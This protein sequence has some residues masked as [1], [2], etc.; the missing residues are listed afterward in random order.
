[1]LPGAATTSATDPETY[2]EPTTKQWVI[3]R[4]TLQRIH[5]AKAKRAKVIRVGA[6]V[7]HRESAELKQ[8]CSKQTA[9]LSR[10]TK[11]QIKVDDMKQAGAVKQSRQ[12]PRRGRERQD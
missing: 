9:S 4:N 5:T 8:L 6:A 11:T 12:T 7:S 3:H 2:G 10:R 1:M